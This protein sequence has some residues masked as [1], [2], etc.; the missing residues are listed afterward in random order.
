M[1]MAKDRARQILKEKLSVFE[2]FKDLIRAAHAV[3]QEL[4]V[5]LKDELV[6]VVE[7]VS[8]K[9]GAVLFHEGDAPED[10]YLIVDGEVGLPDSERLA[11]R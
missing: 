4:P 6:T 7:Q 1:A 8:Y 2:L 11:T 3:Q 5:A 10:I 9:E